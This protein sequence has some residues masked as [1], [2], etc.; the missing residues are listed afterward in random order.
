MKN[1]FPELKKVFKKEIKINDTH[2]TKNS[3][4]FS[5]SFYFEF[6]S[7]NI[8]NFNKILPEIKNIAENNSFYLLHKL[9][10]DVMGEEYAYLILK[11]KKKTIAKLKKKLYHI[12]PKKN[13]KRILKEGLVPQKFET[14]RWKDNLNYYYEPAIFCTKNKDDAEFLFNKVKY[15]IWEI[16]LTGINNKWFVD[17]NMGFNGSFLTHENIKPEALKLIIE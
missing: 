10:T 15:D 17:I 12:S 11:N 6:N 8:R 5:F 16:N 1:I 3:N 14:S 7:E 9:K 2:I 13:R 4:Y